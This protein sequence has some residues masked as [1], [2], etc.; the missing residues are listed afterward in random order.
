LAPEPDRFAVGGGGVW[1][2]RILASVAW[3]DVAA[4]GIFAPLWLLYA[5][6][7][8][9]GRRPWASAGLAGFWLGLAWLSGHHEVPLL[10]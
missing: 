2:R 10:V 3:S 7:A 4:G 5:A 8:V 9:R 1:L 6:R